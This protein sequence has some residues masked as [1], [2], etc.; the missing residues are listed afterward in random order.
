MGVYIKDMRMPT[1]CLRC[2]LWM[3]CK[4][5]TDSAKRP[6]DCPLIEVAEPHGRLVDADKLPIRDISIEYY[7][8][9]GVIE[10]DIDNAPTVIGAEGE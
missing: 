6:N 4:Q 8:I 5:F 2:P 1:N 7:A 9:N 3:D 10:D